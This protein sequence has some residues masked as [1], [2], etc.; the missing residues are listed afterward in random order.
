MT[1]GEGSACWQGES[2]RGRGFRVITGVL[3]MVRASA[4]MKRDSLLTNRDLFL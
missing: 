1:L 3:R 2:W 4:V